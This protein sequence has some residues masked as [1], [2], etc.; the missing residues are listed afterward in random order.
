MWFLFDKSTMTATM[1]ELTILWE[2]RSLEPPLVP[3]RAAH[4]TTKKEDFGGGKKE[5]R[6]K[7]SVR[8][9]FEVHSKCNCFEN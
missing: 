1:V 5:G 6:E 9:A 4:D 7:T 3:E 2:T 8:R